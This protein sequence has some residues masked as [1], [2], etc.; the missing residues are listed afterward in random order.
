[1]G[2]SAFVPLLV[3]VTAIM[4]LFLF[5][6]IYIQPWELTNLTFR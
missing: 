5:P 6:R 1:M 2:L 3:D 4:G